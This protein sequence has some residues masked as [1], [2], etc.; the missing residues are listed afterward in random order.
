MARPADASKSGTAML[1]LKGIENNHPLVGEFK[2]SDGKPYDYSLV[3]NKG[4]VVAPLLL[5]RL[6]L[7]VGDSIKIGGQDFQIRGVVTEEPGGTTGFRLGPR[8]FIERTAFDAAGLTEFGSRNRRKILFRTTAAENAEPL[9]AALR[10]ALKQTKSIVA[11]RSYKEAQENTSE[12]F[13]RAE[14]FLSLTGLVILVLGGIGVWNVT[15]V[16]VEQKKQSIA[17]LKCIG[18]TGTGVTLAYL[19]QILT[20][21]LLGS[22]FGVLLAQLA[23]FAIKQNF[24][25]DLP[26]AMTYNLQP[27]AISQGFLLGLAVSALF[28][29][30]PLLEIR[31]I[32]PRLLLRD[33]TN[34]ALRKFAPVNFLVG[35]FVV[36]GLLLLAVWQANSWRIGTYF[37]IGLAV[38]AGVLYLAA[39]VLTKLLRTLRG[40]SVFALRQSI[41]SL[42]RPGNQ[43]R[44]ILMAV[45]LG[46]FVVL[47]V[48]SLQSNLLKEFDLT[49]TGSL[50]TLFLI[51]IRRNQAEQLKEFLKQ[52]TGET[53][54][55]IP[56]VRGRIAAI[57]DQPIDIE[58]RE[59]RQQSGQ[60]GRE[61]VL[62]Y[63][64]NLVGEEQ[65]TAG[66][67]WDATASSE[68]EVSLEEG[69]RDA[70]KVNVGDTITF[71][72]S[73]QRIT[74]KVTSFRRLDVRNTRSTFLIVFRPG[75]LENA[76]QTLL[77]P[78]YTS[79]SAETKRG[80][81]RK[82]VDQ[83]PNISAIDTSD[84]VTAIKKL[85]DNITLAVS[86]V[87]GFVFL[88]GALILIGSIAL[89]KFQRIY[90]NA[91]LKTLGAKRNTLLLILLAEYSLL[92]LLAGVVGAVAATGLSYVV[93]NYVF[94]IIWR[95]D[96]T[97]LSVGLLVTVLLV[98]IV[99]AI[100]SFDVLL[101]KPLA[102]LR[103]Q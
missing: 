92:G 79:F 51:D 80:L 55:Y 101:R 82:L 67:F 99:G 45:G 71:D 32:K 53:V 95:P 81:Q 36:A 61:Y 38:T 70:L 5:E 78:L 52:E 22:A 42:S 4:A 57:N 14:N 3:A 54:E 20:L 58:Q 30:L 88:S 94:K 21:G 9:A 97:L 85:V 64:Q 62:T 19:L 73:G 56:A 34:E 26:P 16:F 6:G 84:A 83:F 7:Q 74:A 89:T 10:S 11:V 15:R 8:V 49:R 90:E 31:Q 100:S 39:F 103:S 1:E 86:F 47:S 96:W 98:T 2:M 41:N 102:T 76:P 68:P 63:R 87:G 72:I 27:A 75:V 46:V 33:G 91:V 29:A 43:T 18:A 48:Q 40:V 65:V 44:V 13:N 37:L 17:V 60:I 69:L 59:I 50:P 23:L 77:A 25:D 12:S 24:A 66:Q 93:A 35:V 28:A